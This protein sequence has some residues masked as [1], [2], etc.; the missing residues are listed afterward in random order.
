MVFGVSDVY[1][2]GTLGR[3]QSSGLHMTAITVGDGVDKR[4]NQRQDCA[5]I[6]GLAALAE[7]RL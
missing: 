3:A 4:V 7:G 5:R 1:L 6:R 2:Y